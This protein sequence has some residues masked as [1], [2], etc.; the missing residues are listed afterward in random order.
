MNEKIRRSENHPKRGK[1]HLGNTKSHGNLGKKHTEET[2]QKISKGNLGKKHPHTEETKQKISRG[3]R[4]IK[5]TE[6]TRELLRMR[7]WSR[8]RMNC[9]KS[10]DEAVVYEFFVKK[11]LCPIWQYQIGS[12]ICDFVFEDE[13]VCVELDGSVHDVWNRRDRD[14]IKDRAYHDAGWLIIRIK[15]KNIEDDWDEIKNKI[16]RICVVVRFIQL[17]LR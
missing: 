5:C 9:L 1:A 11:G 3:N 12:Y 7:V 6:E 16:N 10:D 15:Y 8:K 14:M 13:R 2:K 4:G 17:G